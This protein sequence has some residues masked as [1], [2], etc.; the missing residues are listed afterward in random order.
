MEVA[1]E[2]TTTVQQLCKMFNECIQIEKT[3]EIDK[4]Y[5]FNPKGFMCDETGA[6]FKGMEEVFGP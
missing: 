6:N 1:S 3:K 4:T 2:S 5:Q